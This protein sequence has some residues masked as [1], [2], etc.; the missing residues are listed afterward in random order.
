MLL[1][2]TLLSSVRRF[3]L[4]VPLAAAGVGIVESLLLGSLLYVRLGA[5]IQTDKGWQRLVRMRNRTNGNHPSG[6]EGLL[7]SVDEQEITSQESGGIE[8][9]GQQDPGAA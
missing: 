4:A 1:Y 7:K 3:V 6:A 2:P 5:K 8:R 9:P